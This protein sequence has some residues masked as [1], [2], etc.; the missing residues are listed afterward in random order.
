MS[1]F[2]EIETDLLK[3]VGEPGTLIPRVKRPLLK[4]KLAQVLKEYESKMDLENIPPR[5]R[6]LA[7]RASIIGSFPI[8]PSPTREELVSALDFNE[9]KRAAKSGG[10]LVYEGSNIIAAMLHSVLKEVKNRKK[11]V[12]ETIFAF[13]GLI[14]TVQKRNAFLSSDT[15][16]II[17]ELCGRII[18]LRECWDHLKQGARNKFLALIIRDA[19][20][21]LE[22]VAHDPIPSGVAVALLN[23]LGTVTRSIPSLILSGLREEPETHS[24]WTYAIRVG[25][26]G[27][28]ESLVKGDVQVAEKLYSTGLE[29]GEKAQIENILREVRYQNEGE[30]RSYVLEWIDSKLLGEYRETSRAGIPQ[31]YLRGSTLTRNLSSAL[32][33]SWEASDKAPDSAR[34]HEILKSV[35]EESFGLRLRGKPGSIVAYDST[36]HELISGTSA[37]GQPVSLLKPIVEW[38]GEEGIRIVIK[39]A[40]KP[41]EEKHD[42]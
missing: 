15:I 26:N 39:G 27:L 6:L 24:S 42:K 3:Y 16:E 12:R 21:V 18:S 10:I 36:L 33:A 38:I 30:L 41:M 29:I 20:S 25:L 32:L 37:P 9:S 8:S 34:C 1:D 22:L 2:T 23:F 31:E 13:R 40:V 7:V 14:R 17:L 11:M 5:V 35:F 4:K 28:R 19:F